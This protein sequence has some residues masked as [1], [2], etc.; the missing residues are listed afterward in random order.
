M[1]AEGIGAGMRSRLGGYARRSPP[2][3]NGAVGNRVITAMAAKPAPILIASSTRQI[4]DSFAS[5][6]LLY[7]V[8]SKQSND[9]ES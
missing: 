2:Q 5:G 4:T 8:A 3:R 7:F 1:K 6:Y 9:I